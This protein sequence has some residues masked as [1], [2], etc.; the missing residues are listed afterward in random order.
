[1]KAK[2]A[3]SSHVPPSPS[4]RDFLKDTTVLTASLLATQALARGQQAAPPP[5]AA[6][7][8]QEKPPPPA[9]PP[10]PEPL[11]KIGVIG[12]GG[13]GRGHCESIVGLHKEG[14]ENVKIVAVCDVYKMRV[15]STVEFLSKEQ[16]ENGQPFAVQGYR[17][18]HE[19]L[20]NP[21]VQGV[22][23][24]VPEH[25]HAQVAI[26]AIRAGKDVYLE[27]PMT[28][29]LDD[30]FALWREQRGSD[31]I[32]Q[33]GTQ[34]VTLPR[35]VEARRLIKEG[36]IGH[37][38]SSQTSYCRNSKTGEWNY[39]AIEPQAVPGENL[40]W[41]TWCGPLGP[42][43]FDP[44]LFAR[45]RRYKRTSTGI[46]GDLLV[47]WMTPMIWALDVGWP[48]RVSATGG[49]Y[50]DKAMENHD[51]VN[52]TAQF[53]G[54][55]TMEV[56]GSTCNATGIETMIRGHKGNLYLAGN[57]CEMRPE[58]I[59]ADEVEPKTTKFESV[60]DQDLLRMNWLHCIRTREPNLSQVELGT[61]V[62]VIVDL[63]TRSLWEGGSFGFSP[64]SM[65]SFRI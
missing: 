59:F 18:Y 53:E 14:K 6:P 21:D 61:K 41:T 24:A 47:H 54:E 37:P 20:K 33:I 11:V 3:S 55:H 51:Q 35:Y 31:R 8:P 43:P 27:K 58:Q 28:L 2:K 34:Y 64:A 46:I 40:D 65:T 15:E 22:L 25:W 4:R 32:V 13:M 19:L 12:I 62:M 30:A 57:S 7:P 1:M 23:I 52:I 49:H 10:R 50:V 42:I 38:C 9:P 44:L 63:A 45:W 56:L 29:R 48:V 36:A 39:Y 17:D 26:D 16:G 5:A 60:P